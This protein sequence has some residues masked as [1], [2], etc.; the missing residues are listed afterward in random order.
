MERKTKIYLLYAG[1]FGLIIVVAITNY[2][3]KLAELKRSNIPVYEYSTISPKELQEMMNKNKELIIVDTRIKEYYDEGHIKGAANLPYTS[4]KAMDKALKK[5]K[6][7]DIVLYSE[8]GDRSKKI[9]EILGTLGYSKL[10]N[11][12]GGI[13]GWKESIGEVVKES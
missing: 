2:L 9:C 13:K 10:K 8:D 7:E 11:L 1:L 5:R 12:D 4:M 6:S 3:I